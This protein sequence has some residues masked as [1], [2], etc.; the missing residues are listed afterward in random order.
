MCHRL[1]AIYEDLFTLYDFYFSDIGAIQDS[2]H[3]IFTAIDMIRKEIGY[4]SERDK[5]D[6]QD[7]PVE[8]DKDENARKEQLHKLAF[9]KVRELKGTMEKIAKSVTKDEAKFSVKFMGVD[10]HKFVKV[11]MVVALSYVPS[12]FKK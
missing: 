4:R 6:G 11:A 9:E 1:A 10:F 12:L 2:K 8:E 3:L 5:N 7:I